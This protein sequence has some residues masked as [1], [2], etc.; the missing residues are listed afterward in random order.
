VGTPLVLP[1]IDER[2]RRLVK[3]TQKWRI[4]IWVRP[5]CL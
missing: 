3:S 1:V 5:T 2:L 4:W